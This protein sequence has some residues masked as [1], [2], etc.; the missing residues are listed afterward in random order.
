MSRWRH[1]CGRVRPAAASGALAVIVYNNVE[2][3]VTA[4]TLSS[5]SADFV[6]AGFINQADGLALKKRLQ[7]GEKIEV[8]FQQEQIVEERITQNVFLE[9]KD[10][11]PNNVVVVCL[12]SLVFTAT[13]THML[14]FLSLE[15]I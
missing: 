5:P 6:P 8:Y 14:T 7:A 9:S 15:L 4:G 12:L 3:N 13:I 1:T 2:T 11:D 10:G